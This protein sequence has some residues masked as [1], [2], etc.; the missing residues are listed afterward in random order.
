MNTELRKELKL[1]LKKTFKLMNSSAFGKAI[2]HVRK[3]RYIEP[4][5]IDKE[6]NIWCL[7]KVLI[8]QSFSQKNCYQ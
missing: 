3:H 6:E 2:K 4:V 1:T 8:Q 7:S 5:T